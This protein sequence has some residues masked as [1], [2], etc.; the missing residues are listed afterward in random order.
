ML[1]HEELVDL[2]RELREQNVLSVY[3]D[4]KTNDFSERKLW[5]RR[6]E[7][8]VSEA[9]KRL[10]GTAP[11]EGG[12]FDGALGRVKEALEDFD[13][14]LP[15]RGWV[16]FATPER[17]V[18]AQALRV[19]MPDLVRWE[20][21]IRV[22]PYVRAL[23]QERPVACVLVDSQHARVFEY[24]DGTLGEEIDLIAETFIDDLTD[25]NVSKRAASHTGVRGK[26]GKDAAQRYLEVGSERMMKELMKL[27]GER[28]GT[29]GLLVIGGTPEAIARAANHLPNELQSR[30]I[31]RPSMN[32]E[33]SDAQVREEVE[34]AASQL[35]QSMQEDL[36]D[37]VLDQARSGGKGALGPEAVE[38]ALREGRVDTLLLSRNFIRANGDYAD[39]LVGAA[40]EHHGDVEE[41]S[42]EGAERLDTEG[43]GTAARLRYVISN[44]AQG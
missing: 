25:V 31:Q 13:Q 38:K 44:E 33:L 8:E 29:H 2:Y 21:G 34:S 27:V 23:K 16:G 41:L 5:R 9:R 6:L 1:N 4:G 30:S 18:L 20:E 7:H 36:L 11:D 40:F 10:N 37:H 12:A 22:A 3:L 14:F 26:T 19:P 42:N 35:N 28:T 32:L 43:Q 15:D 17:L 24:R 39:H